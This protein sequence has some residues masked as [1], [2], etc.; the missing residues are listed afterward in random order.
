MDA[1]SSG[2]SLTFTK[3]PNFFL[4][5]G[6]HCIKMRFIC[7]KHKLILMPPMLVLSD[8]FAVQVKG[9]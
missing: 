8:I 7:Q 6:L 4:E 2:L 5:S 9:R 1:V 3:C